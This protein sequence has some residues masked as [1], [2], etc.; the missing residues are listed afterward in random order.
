MGVTAFTGIGGLGWGVTWGIRN[1]FRNQMQEAKGLAPTELA[2]DPGRKQPVRFV[3]VEAE[4]LTGWVGLGKA[5]FDV[6]SATTAL[7]RSTSF[8]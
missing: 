2:A 6:Y 5:G 4:K 3:T 7:S 8:A 1:I